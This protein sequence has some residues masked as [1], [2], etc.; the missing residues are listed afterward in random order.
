M[1]SPSRIR[2]II[3]SSDDTNFQGEVDLAL[4]K[5]LRVLEGRREV[6]LAEVVG[7]KQRVVAKKFIVGEK[8]HRE[9]QREITGLRELAQRGIPGP[10]LIFIAEDDVAAIWVVA[11]YIEDSV[12][13]SDVLVN[14]AMPDSAA[15][16]IRSFAQTLV[17]HWRKGVHQTDVHNRNYLWDGRALYTIDVGSIRFQSDVASLQTRIHTLERTCYKF[18]KQQWS[19]FL[20]AYEEITGEAEQ[21][22]QVDYLRSNQFHDRLQQRISKELKRVWLKSQ[23]SSSDT[24]LFQQKGVKLY[25]QPDA[26]A[27]LIDVVLSAPDSLMQQGTRLKSGNTCTVQLIEW[28]GR[29]YV[30][31]R[32]NRKSLF[33]RLR[34]VFMTSRVI[35]SWANAR[36]LNR[37]RVLTP[38]VVIACEFR[39]CGIPDRGF[40]VM[41]HID[42][43]TLSHYMAQP[44]LA[45]VDRRKYIDE[46][47]EL[48]HNLYQFRIVHGDMKA[49]NLLVGEGKLW[50]IDVDGMKLSPCGSAFQKLFEKDRSRFLRNWDEFPELKNEFEEALQTE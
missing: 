41:E 12:D 6:W 20:S 42:G 31:K 10:K 24:N 13:M 49:K 39:K 7:T 44:D 25:S 45:E 47:R 1:S 5:T 43:E 30:V 26:D 32:Y 27:S 50:L 11:E 23:R 40:L 35:Q 2:L 15:E 48:F 29:K 16:A 17:L 28:G 38:T 9:S 3:T 22:L 21:V 4:V 14:G 36:V 37:F 33:Y 8:Q 18:T 19:R 34:H 46:A